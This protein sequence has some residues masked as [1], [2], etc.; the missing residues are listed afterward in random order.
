M[1]GL[2]DQLG[3]ILARKEKNLK[4]VA[5]QAA[6][7]IAEKVTEQS[8][9]GR[10]FGS[11]Q[12]DNEYSERYANRRKGGA[13]SPVTLRDRAT[14]IEDTTVT[15]GGPGEAQIRFANDEFARIARYHHEG[16]AGNSNKVRSIF[17][18]TPESVPDD[19]LTN[20]K[21][22]VQNVLKP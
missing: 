16:R 12:Y 19:I 1:Q 14:D 8:R 11:D 18:K 15:L 7:E 6:K 2:G 5:E 22:G 13:L 9:E 3:V 10:G 4:Q 17:P 21:R 20:I